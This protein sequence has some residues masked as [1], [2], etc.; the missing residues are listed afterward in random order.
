[1]PELATLYVNVWRKRKST[2]A[3][4]AAERIIDSAKQEATARKKEM[5]LEA[6]DEVHRLRTEADKDILVNVEMELQP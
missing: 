1:M 3:E 6:K 4:E 2:S 5:I